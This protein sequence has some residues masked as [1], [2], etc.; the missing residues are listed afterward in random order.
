[1]LGMNQATYSLLVYAGVSLIISYGI[2]RIFFGRAAD[3][4]MGASQWLFAALIWFILM[5]GLFFY[6]RYLR[7]VF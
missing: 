3:R 6:N 4:G 1:M 7:F 2:A 5:L